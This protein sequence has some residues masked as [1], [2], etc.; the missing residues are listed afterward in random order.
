MLASFPYLYEDEIVYSAMARYHNR[1]GNIDF[2][3]TT[4]DLY[5]DARPYIISDLT[6]GLEI[7]QK[8]LKCFAEIDMNDWLDNH[9]LFHYYTNF[10]NE[11]VKD[12][13]K[14]EMLGNER[15]GNLHSLTG[16]IASSV[17]EPL[18]FRFCIQCLQEDLIRYGETYW[19]TYQQLPS[20]FVCLKHNVL[21]QSSCVRFRQD[22]STIIAASEKS[23]MEGINDN[24]QYKISNQEMKILMYLAKESYQLVVTNYSYDLNELQNIYRYLLQKKGYISIKGTVKQNELARDF[25]SFFGENILSLM[26]SMV[27]EDESCWLKAITRKH[28][29]SFH[30]IRHMLFIYFMGQ[31]VSSIREWKGKYYCYFGEAPYLCLNP[32]ADHYLKAVINDVKVTRCSNTKEPIGT[33]ECLCGFI[34]S[35]RGP[36]INETDKMKIGRIKAFGD[37]WTAKLEKYILDDKLSYRAC[38]KLL[39]VDTNTI[40]KYSKKQLNSQL[41]HIESASLN[42][43]KEAWLVLIKEYPLLSKTELRKK[44]SALYMRLYRKDKEWLSLN[45]PIKSEV[46][47]IRERINWKIRDNEILNV[48]EKA[49]NFLLSKEKLTRISIAS[50]GREIKKKALLEKHLD[51]L[52]KTRA[53]I[54]QVIE[55][56][57]DFQIRRFKWAIQECRKSGEELI[58]WKVLRKAGLSKKNL[59][60]DF[61]DT[62]FSENI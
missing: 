29:N 45:S 15:N 20:V 16:Q 33:F 58:G 28:R 14:K 47:K 2:K 27:K 60:G 53:Y 54:S 19:R 51:K 5:G 49:V 34:Y 17:M 18:Y 50:I 59:K 48:V 56:I 8:Q 44:N 1:S 36:D 43:Y 42:Q 62:F 24:K 35:R 10:T 22:S 52:P 31:S 38:A 25:V 32:A 61:Y 37:V 23:C 57:H 21:L 55:S 40:I 41:N 4:R 6:S 12:K 30:P 39:K 3:D 46:K 9:T 11:A 13:V 7:L 26:Q